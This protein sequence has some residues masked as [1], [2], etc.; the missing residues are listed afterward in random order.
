MRLT[1]KVITA[2]RLAHLTWAA[3]L[4]SEG[5]YI[6]IREGSTIGNRIKQWRINVRCGDMEHTSSSQATLDK[7]KVDT[8]EGLTLAMDRAVQWLRG[9]RAQTNKEIPPHA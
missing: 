9:A 8:F 6:L 1:D 7:D 2:E 3:A 5:G 4:L